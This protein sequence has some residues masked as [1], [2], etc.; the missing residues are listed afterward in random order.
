MWTNDSLAVMQKH[1]KCAYKV[2]NRNLSSIG[3]QLLMRHNMVQGHSTP[4]VEA[5]DSDFP[6]SNSCTDNGPCYSPHFHDAHN[7]HVDNT[8]FFANKNIDLDS[9]L[10]QLRNLKTLNGASVWTFLTRITLPC[11]LPWVTNPDS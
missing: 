1:Y 3:I 11:H 7:L 5:D 8:I 9:S 6:H 2:S 4:T 10:A